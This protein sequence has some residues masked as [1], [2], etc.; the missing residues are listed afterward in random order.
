MKLKK[1]IVTRI[2]LH[3]GWGKYYR[4]YNLFIEM[5]RVKINYGRSTVQL[6][7]FSWI[8]LGEHG[9][10]F[11]AEILDQMTHTLAK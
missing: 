11:P 6:L 4:P 2:S 10:A 8:F 7:I 5:G 3:K 9:E 1:H